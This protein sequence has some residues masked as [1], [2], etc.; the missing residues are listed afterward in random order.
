M[1][2]GVKLEK[3]RRL[4]YAAEAFGSYDNFVRAIG[5]IYDQRLLCAFEKLQIVAQSSGSVKVSAIIVF[6][7]RE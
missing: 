5:A 7:T 2:S 1:I 4:R 3:H 6:T